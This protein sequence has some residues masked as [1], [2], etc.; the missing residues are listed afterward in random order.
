MLAAE[1]GMP[2]S[3]K[4]YKEIELEVMSKWDLLKSVS[5]G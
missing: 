1:K 5:V 3:K 4:A 2:S